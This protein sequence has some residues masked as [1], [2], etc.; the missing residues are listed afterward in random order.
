LLLLFRTEWMPFPPS[1]DRTIWSSVIMSLRDG[2]LLF[3]DFGFVEF[4]SCL[5][6]DCEGWS[7]PP[8]VRDC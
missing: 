1:F 6:D 7:P 4:A 3:G 5:F 8:V 2:L